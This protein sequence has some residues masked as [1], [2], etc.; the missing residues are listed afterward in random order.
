M[1]QT[2]EL[3]NIQNEC[4]NIYIQC[5]LCNK[6]KYYIMKIAIENAVFVREKMPLKKGERKKRKSYFVKAVLSTTQYAI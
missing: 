2:N 4:N 1:H 6:N 5:L 3:L